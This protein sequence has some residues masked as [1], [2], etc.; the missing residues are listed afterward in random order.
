MRAI[1]LRNEEL[2]T[3][4]SCRVV[5]RSVAAAAVRRAPR[6]PRPTAAVENRA[7]PHPATFIRVA[8]RPQGARSHA[9][10]KSDLWRVASSLPVT[11]ARGPSGVKC[12]PANSRCHVRVSLE[13]RL[14]AAKE[15]ARACSS[16]G[17]PQSD[18]PPA[19]ARGQCSSDVALVKC[20]HRSIS[21]RAWPAS[22]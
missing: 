13:R 7:R 15:A 21:M 4:L 19:R 5:R 9:S 12:P 17:Q 11:A 20:W 1:R 6:L 22:A 14:G 3:Y 8:N 10:R 16:A 18:A 2:P